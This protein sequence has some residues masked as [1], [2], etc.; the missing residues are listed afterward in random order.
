MFDNIT[1]FRLAN[2][3]VYVILDDLFNNNKIF[4]FYRQSNQSYDA[5]FVKSA[6]CCNLGAD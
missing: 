5:Q 4:G 6:L 3:A 2:F 1:W